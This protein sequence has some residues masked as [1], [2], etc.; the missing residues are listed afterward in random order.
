MNKLEAAREKSD[1]VRASIGEMKE[2]ERQ[3]TSFIFFNV[4]ESVSDVSETKKDH[5]KQEVENILCELEL[6]NI[7]ISNKM[8]RLAKSKIPAHADKPC[9]LRVSVA[10]EEQRKE[11]LQA[12]KKPRGEQEAQT[13]N[14]I[15]EKRHDSTRDRKWQPDIAPCRTETPREENRQAQGRG[16]HKEPGE[17]R[18]R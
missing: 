2:R 9:P 14:S 11:I 3:K 7:E 18:G 17:E 16:E 1:I 5:D 4:E 13:K 8:T 6:K 15:H 12:V 10:S